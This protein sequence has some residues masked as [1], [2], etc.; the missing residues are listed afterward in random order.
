[1]K[2]PLPQVPGTLVPSMSPAS[3]PS[4]LFSCTSFTLSALTHTQL[5]QETSKLWVTI[6]DF[7][8]VGGLHSLQLHI[9]VDVDLLIE[10]DIN[11]A[12]AVAS[13]FACI[14]ACRKQKCGDMTTPKRTEK[15]NRYLLMMSTKAVSRKQQAPEARGTVMDLGI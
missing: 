10:A 4:S 1:M 8:Q 13:S 9:P 12:G 14:K 7:Q 6:Q 15:A 11:Q 5:L 3:S 2:A